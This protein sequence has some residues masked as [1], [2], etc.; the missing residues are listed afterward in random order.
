MT[1]PT[2]D[3]QHPLSN[4]EPI[5][6]DPRR[7]KVI[8]AGR[9]FSK[10]RGAWI[11]SMIGHGPGW[12]EFQPMW[13][14]VLQ[15][16]DVVWLAP[17]FPQA[18]SIWL[19]EVK[20]RCTELEGVNLN[21]TD[22]T[23]TLEGGGHLHIRSA[24]AV[25]SIRGLGARV[26]GV[27]IDEAAWL[28]LESHWRD[29]IRPILMDNHGWA[30]IMSTTNAGLDGN[31]QHRTP[32]FFN[33]LCLEIQSGQRS[34]EE[35]V[36]FYGTAMDNPLIAAEDFLSLVNEYP[37]DSPSL[38]Q[39]VFAKLLTAGAGIAFP[40][41]R[42][43]HHRVGFEIPPGWRW[44]GGLDWGYAKPGCCLLI[45]A[46]PDGDL[47]VRYELYFKQQTPYEMGY[48]VGQRCRTIPDARVEWIGCDSAMIAVTDGGP[49]HYEEFARGL[50]DATFDAVLGVV[51]LVS[52]PKGPGS[53]VAGKMLVHEH[54]RVKR[55]P[56]GSI[57][58]WGRAKLRVHESC[59]NLLRTLPA[60]PISPKNT[61][62]VDT[63]AEDHPYDSLRYALM[64][65][66]PR[67]LVEEGYQVEQDHHPGFDL[68][69]R[70]RRPRW[71][72][73]QGDPELERAELL[74]Q[75]RFVTGVRMGTPR[76]VED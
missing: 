25:E 40:E 66:A 14:G 11:A 49:S 27:V 64:C 28:D 42:D 73:A 20:P 61:E 51:P 60:L 4:Q 65:R 2:L 9:R 69:R 48:V 53:R 58:P 13:E 3:I 17:D 74:R 41:W 31:P 32:S 75:G 38:A 24:Q 56:D 22:M 29:V 23:V 5:F 37:P 21:N 70:Q 63:E 8:R 57:P 44:F 62:D 72:P 6:N 7:F 46:G 39:E 35:W 71:Q 33:L 18:R 12:E 16:W 30:I 55:S 59:V 50:K 15:G 52:A 47:V 36:E 43:D 68:K 45:A 26:K 54:L 10:T 34:A 76:P 67:P 1:A 19:E